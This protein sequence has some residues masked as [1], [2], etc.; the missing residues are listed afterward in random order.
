MVFRK[1]TKKTMS[2]FLIFCLTISLI[3]QDGFQI[4]AEEMD[5]KTEIVYIDDVG[6]KVSYNFEGKYTISV[7][8]N[9]AVNGTVDFGEHGT[10]EVTIHNE[11]EETENY[12]LDIEELNTEEV[13]VDVYSDGQKVAE[14]NDV[15]E[16]IEDE[17]VGQAAITAT[18]TVISLK[19]LLEIIITVAAT[20]VIAAMTCEALSVAYEAIK[21][22]KKKQGNYYRAWLSGNDVYIRMDDP[23]DLDLAVSRIS[24]GFSIYTYTS[25]QASNV[26]YLTGLGVTASEIDSKANRKSGHIYYRHYHTAN[27]NGAHAW[28]GIG[29]YQD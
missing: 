10:A 12:L 22:S 24:A 15:D 1:K 8:G 6:Y 29:Y 18:V 7:V 14:Y 20:A 11:T 19:T 13:D 26:C 9:E 2:Y 27:R 25:S 4:R 17:Y 23:I 28:Y 5:E 21:E 3:W 16:I